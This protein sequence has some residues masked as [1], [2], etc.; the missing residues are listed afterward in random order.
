MREPGPYRICALMMK[1]RTDLSS[2]RFR[3]RIASII[4]KHSKLTHYQRAKVTPCQEWFFGLDRHRT[5]GHIQ[6]FQEAGDR[7]DDLIAENADKNA[8]KPKCNLVPRHE[9]LVDGSVGRHQDL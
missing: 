8:S 2:L 7:R 5:P 6:N 3:S 9:L 1:W 4:N